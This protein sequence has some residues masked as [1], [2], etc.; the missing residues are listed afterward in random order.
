MKTK[1]YFICHLYMCLIASCIFW[2]CNNEIFDITINSETETNNPLTRASFDY[3]FDWDRLNHFAIYNPNIGRTDSIEI[4]WRTGS[5]NSLGIPV[6]W[7]DENAFNS[8]TN[9]RYYSRE[10]HWVLVYSNLM[11]RVT[12]KYFALYNTRTGIMRIFFYALSNASSGGNSSSFWGLRINKASSLFNFTYSFAQAADK[13]GSTPSFISS[14]P[15][16]VSGTTFS[17][18]GYQVNNWYGIE[19]ECAYD[20]TISANSGHTFQM[21]GWAADINKI[22]GTGVTEGSIEGTIEY[23]ASVGNF[24]LS[25]SNLLNESRSQNTYN[26]SNNGGVVEG[27][28]G[29]IEEGIKKKDPFFKGLWN[30]IKKKATTGIGDGVKS[31][32]AT[33]V[34]SGGSI[35]TTALKEAVTS[36]TGIGGGI[37]SV[38]KVN[39]SLAS[40]TKLE[41]NGETILPGYGA[42]S[43]FPIPG[44][45]TNPTNMPLYN[46]NLGAWNLSQT[47]KINIEGICHNFFVNSEFHKSLLHFRYYVDCNQNNLILNEEIRNKVTIRNF[48]VSIGFID[49]QWH[50]Y[51]FI[52]NS[53]GQ[54]YNGGPNPAAFF[55]DKC[56]YSDDTAMSNGIIKPVMYGALTESNEYQYVSFISPDQLYHGN[57]KAI[58]SFDMV[59]NATNKVYSFAKWFDT[60]FGQQKIN[61]KT[62]HV[63]YPYF[64]DNYVETLMFLPYFPTLDRNYR[65]TEDFDFIKP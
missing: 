61:Q 51:V 43:P 44:S 54:L 53:D 4:P 36:I 21:K 7:V 10:N 11:E 33:L 14:P 22:T 63:D 26:V 1:L 50:N 40:N 60:Q 12:N 52:G 16:M 56:Y 35:A 13:Q 25:L 47:P 62:I 19:I 55:G 6:E 58:I 34:S 59:D 32:L 27:L 42:I 48:K 39:L 2:S 30:N 41:L 31:G 65:I 9:E 17:G 24:N 64:Y 8:R 46:K 37:P 15:G 18:T 23:K 3:Y 29:S 20:P 57:F 5:S 45:S 28:G 49:D 38:G